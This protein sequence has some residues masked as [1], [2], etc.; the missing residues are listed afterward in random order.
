MLPE[1]IVTLLLLL[2]PALW[3]LK[4]REVE[5][6]YW[7]M[8][9]KAGFL[10]S[11]FDAIRLG[12]DHKLYFLLIAAGLLPALIA[13]VLYRL[14]MSGGADVLVLAL[15]AVSSPL[16]PPKLPPIP[17]AV[18]VA[19]LAGILGLAYNYGTLARACGLTCVRR[20]YVRVSRRQAIYSPFYRW[21]LPRNSE[22]KVE[23]TPAS[24]GEDEVELMPGVPMVSITWLAY[25]L[26]TLTLPLII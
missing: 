6:L 13:L 11:L 9:I 14:C 12:I 22:C 3:D 25:L 7:Y 8:A 23:H 16:P 21:W 4:Y 10:V 26:Y 19:V 24:L 17:P 15:I 1:H 18:P 2:P 20:G 5:P